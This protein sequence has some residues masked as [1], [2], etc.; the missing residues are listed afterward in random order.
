MFTKKLKKC[1]FKK[2]A[3]NSSNLQKKLSYS[4][5][6][7]FFGFLKRFCYFN[8]QILFGEKY[9]KIQNSSSKNTFAEF[10]VF[11]YCAT[12]NHKCFTKQTKNNFLAHFV[13]NIMGKFFG[14]NFCFNFFQIKILFHNNED[15]FYLYFMKF[16]MVFLSVIICSQQF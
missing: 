13:K 5:Q 12:N 4:F 7:S 3:K 14:L 15:V 11:R 6:K 1:I 10:L 2:S 16:R 8:F 9:S